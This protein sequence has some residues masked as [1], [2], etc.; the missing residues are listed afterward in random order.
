VLDQVVEA[1]A[2]LHRAGVLHR[3]VKPSNVLVDGRGHVQ[4]SDFGL[5]RLGE[6]AALTSPGHELGTPGFMSPE[7]W[8]G[9]LDVDARAD[10]FGL[11]ATLYQALT[12][13][14]PFGKARLTTDDPPPA[15]IT[16]LQP[17]LPADFDAVVSKPWS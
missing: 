4:I 16:A 10:L 7:Q 9:K 13:E 3:D 12:L 15:P 14:A 2:V 8:A 5:A 6:E 1:V 11:G 17:L